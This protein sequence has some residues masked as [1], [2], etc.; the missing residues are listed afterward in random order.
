MI[1]ERISLR[2][3]KRFVEPI[4]LDGLTPG[5]NLFVGP[6]EAGKST[7]VEAI[8]AAF[9]ERYRTSKATD[10]FPFGLSGASPTIELEMELD[11]GRYT[12][13]KTFGKRAGCVLSG[14]TGT[15]HD[16]EA[17]EFLAA[18]L[19]FSMPLRG[20]SKSEHWGLPG[21][22]WVTQGTTQELTEPISNAQR[23]LDE[24]LR[25]PL[26]ASVTLTP[27]DVILDKVR[28]MRNALLTA[29]KG[30]STG[31][32][33][34][35]QEAV[36]ELEARIAE[37]EPRIR[38]H[39]SAVDQLGEL[40]K[41]YERLAED[42]PWLDLRKRAAEAAEAIRAIEPMHRELE[43]ARKMAD[44]LRQRIE[45]FDERRRELEELEAERAQ[46]DEIVEKKR[47]HHTE[48]TG[49]L[50]RAE[51]RLAEA[52]E[53]LAAAQR[54]SRR[55][56]EAGRRLRI[57]QDRDDLTRLRA[58]L[59]KNLE[60]A[61]ELADSLSRARGT[62]EASRV[63]PAVLAELKGVANK[64]HENHLL[65]DA[66][67]TVVEY[68][69]EPDRRVSLGES[70]LQGQGEVRL[71]EATAMVVAGVGRFV[72]KPGGRD[73]AALR[74]EGLRLERELEARLAEVGAVS[75][76]DAEAKAAARRNAEGA[77]H[78]A[79]QMLALLAPDGTDALAA[80]LAGVVARI[81]ELD[82]ELATLSPDPEAPSLDRA[83]SEER[84]AS[85]IYETC[86][87]VLEDARLAEGR[88]RIEAE[89]AARSVEELEKRLAE[90]RARA[91]KDEDARREAQE[92]LTKL[93]ASIA[94]LERDL[95][96]AS[97]ETLAQDVE[98]LEKSASAQES[99]YHDLS[100]RITGL[101]SQLE[102]LG[103]LG[104]EE[105]HATL[106][107][108]L[109]RA[110]LRLGELTRRASA[111]DHL[112]EVLER[113]KRA[114]TSSIRAPL[115][116]KLRRYTRHLFEA[117]VEFGDDLAPTRVS[118][119]FGQAAE[120]ATF[121]KLSYGAREQVGLLLRLAYADLLAE[122]GRPTLILLDDALVH[123]DGARL[124]A[125]KRA[126]YDAATR[127][128]ILFF[129]CHPERFDDLGVPARSLLLERNAA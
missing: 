103:A 80:K 127:H 54:A 15:L 4:T 8:R 56:R 108:S 64:L 11:D 9:F 35:A 78:E 31:E 17:E 61:R 99:R 129:T 7:I 44:A 27:G 50:K 76:D 38:E 89:T 42:R 6:N 115:E 49:L 119:R 22:L 24:I 73:L 43:G 94:K 92:E 57:E 55:A 51:A 75:L 88:A 63:T 45:G 98:R 12:L 79:K 28:A 58:E 32:L 117:E 59:E 91:E 62:L 104:L 95:A 66:V 21:L 118:R 106:S 23:Y 126:L 116:E 46:S 33:R 36:R 100:K 19:G 81:A 82:H 5:L 65:L 105:Q 52:Q 67:A 34:A 102:A 83:E 10:L 16:A 74:D 3:L 96:A 114:L 48:T 77:A 40:R 111:L 86:R 87:K 18:K 90:A 97:P 122:A 84:N 70:T 113:E 101:E 30:Q 47:G 14:P 121:D 26:S 124:E 68:A 29:G 60:K 53:A 128:Q 69:I 107:A 123:T 39:A 93:E 37:L 13:V 2:E 120:E 41:E 109:E 85:G 125:M 1:L 112:L 72:I 20:Q 110:R 25:D 71:H